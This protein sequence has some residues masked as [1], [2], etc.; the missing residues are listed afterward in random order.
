MRDVGCEGVVRIVVGK[1][2]QQ[3]RGGP[4]PAK[5]RDGIGD[6]HRRNGCSWPGLSARPFWFA[7]MCRSTPHGTSTGVL[8]SPCREPT[9]HA[10][11]SIRG[12]PEQFSSMLG[13]IASMQTAP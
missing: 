7:H 1:K 4:A 3:R 9:E 8:L 10:L 5:V 13:G 2:E 11:P 12:S 6:L